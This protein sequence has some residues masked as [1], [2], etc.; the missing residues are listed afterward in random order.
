MFVVFINDLAAIPVLHPNYADDLKIYASVACSNTFVVLQQNLDNL[1]DCCPLPLRN[2]VF[3]KSA[4]R[5]G[6]MTKNPLIS[7]FCV[8]I[9]EVC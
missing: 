7:S 6:Q 5:I 3:C 2:A 1:I 9:P 8:V 4:V